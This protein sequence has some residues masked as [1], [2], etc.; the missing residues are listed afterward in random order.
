[1]L[2]LDRHRLGEGRETYLR[3]RR[4]VGAQPCEVC[5]CL[6]NL[7]VP[8][9]ELDAEPVTEL[10]QPSI[11]V[12]TCAS[13][14]T[15]RVVRMCLFVRAR[16]KWCT[17]YPMDAIEKLCCLQNHLD[18]MFI[19]VK[20]RCFPWTSRENEDIHGDRSVTSPDI[21]SPFSDARAIADIHPDLI[22]V[23]CFCELKPVCPEDL[24]TS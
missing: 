7:A 17:T 5:F 8:K 12:E 11:V 20:L 14:N 19:A 9:R 2:V 24:V 18:N 3:D 10:T 15:T 22:V 23:K 4:F 21:T 16:W 6:V 13:P 1:M